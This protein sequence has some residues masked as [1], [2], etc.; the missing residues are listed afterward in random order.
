VAGPIAVTRHAIDLILAAI[1]IC[2][3]AFLFGG[4]PVRAAECGKASF[5]AEAHHG[6]TMANGRPF[7]MHAMTAASNTL[8][9]G[10]NARVTAGQRSVVVKITDTG[11]FGK[12]GRIIDLSKAAFAK[13]APTKQGIAE[14]CVTRLR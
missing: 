14:V 7:N 10:S 3:M 1:L 5:Y 4:P 13:L 11:A 2:G 9:L 6:K 12:Y 8:P